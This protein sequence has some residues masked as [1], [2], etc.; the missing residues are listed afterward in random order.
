MLS[1]AFQL[2]LII[3]ILIAIAY[4]GRKWFDQF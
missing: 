1:L 4:Y 3:L 2:A